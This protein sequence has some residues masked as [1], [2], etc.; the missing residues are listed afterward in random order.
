MAE[1]EP[2]RRRILAALGAAAV[3]FLSGC[4]LFQPPDRPEGTDTAASTSADTATATSTP[5]AGST[6]TSTATPAPADTATPEPATET[7]DRFDP[8]DAITVDRII[9]GEPD[10]DDGD[11]DDEDG[12]QEYEKNRT[13]AVVDVDVVIRNASNRSLGLVSIVLDVVYETDNVSPVVVATGTVSRQW[14][15]GL[16]DGATA[17]LSPDPLYFEQTGA[18]WHDLQDDHYSIDV[19]VRVV[20]PI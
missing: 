20:E 14:P 1:D 8:G 19:T 10:D 12:V 4:G 2:G 16:A 15:D 5:A 6:A 17:T 11:E 7:T 9:F 3:P 13:L 18:P